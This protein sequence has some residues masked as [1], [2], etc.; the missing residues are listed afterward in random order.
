MEQWQWFIISYTLIIVAFI[1]GML[2][3]EAGHEVREEAK[4]N[5]ERTGAKSMLPRQKQPG[6]KMGA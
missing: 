2:W 6:S 5:E 1:C 4:A 3:N